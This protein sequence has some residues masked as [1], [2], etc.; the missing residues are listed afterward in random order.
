MTHSP[1]LQ[2]GA[3]AQTN[4]DQTPPPARNDVLYATHGGV[5]LRGDLYLPS[6]SGPFP[7]V[8]AAPGGGWFVSQKAG[9]R[10]WAEY[11]AQNG[12]ATFA[13][14]Y[15]VAAAERTFPDSACD[16]LAAV[17]FVR[18]SAADL[19]IDPERIGLL[20]SSAGAHL[21][22]LAA[23]GGDAD[24]FRSR[25]PAGGHGGVETTVKAFAGIYGVY[26]L[27]AHW[28]HEITEAP[29]ARSRRSESFLGTS[30]FDDQQIYFDASP[31][32][33]IRH[34]RN[35]TAMFLAYGLADKVVDPQRQSM[36]FGHALRQ[37]G[38]AVRE[39]PI[40]DAS[41]FWFSE[42]QF[43]EPGSVVAAL[44]PRLLRFLKRSL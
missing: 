25:N 36:A 26:D 16:V 14:E 42:E 38:F 8:V 32:S 6:G 29:F 19:N 12:I 3:A 31:M 24:V 2:S 10:S 39:Y 4:V 34:A 7:V 33:H 1:T 9:L 23:L 35:K 17:Q 13:I 40:T 15:R 44:A 22:A 27:F 18:G 11:L 37:A 43:D 30:P 21:T 41:H 5:E 20:G 28:Q